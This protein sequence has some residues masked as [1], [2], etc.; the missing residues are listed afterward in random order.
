MRR[1]LLLLSASTLVIAGA[2]VAKTVTVSITKAGYVPKAVTVEQGDTVQFTNSDTIVHQVEFKSTTGVTCSPNP[3]V[4]QPGASGSCT[5]QSAGSYTYSDPNS[6]GN[7]FRG[8]VTVHAAA[9]SI[10]LAGQPLLVTY[11]ASVALSGKHSTAAAGDSV[12]VLATQ[13]GAN[14]ATKLTTVQ[15]AAG[16][17]FASTAVPR[18]NT[19]YSAKIKNVTSNT[20]AVTV[21]PRLVLRRVAAHRYAVRVSAGQSFAGKYAGFQR[22]NA[23]LKRWVALK[24]VLLKASTTGVAPTV[25]STAS[26]RSSVK[27]GLRVRLTLPKAQVGGCY[28]AGLSN[29]IVS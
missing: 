3:L 27:G 9:E 15:T 28:Q 10:T 18:M 1:L 8:S 19:T 11:G 29:T 22:Y 12:D 25:V 14:A 21:R 6:K 16:G 13:C 20:V 2:A 5:F 7:T 26:F 4:V 23:A 17:T 24:S